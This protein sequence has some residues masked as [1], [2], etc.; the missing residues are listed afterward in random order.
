MKKQIPA[1]NYHVLVFAAILLLASCNSKKSTP[2]P[3]NA[4]GFKAPE[5][6]AFK[7]PE[8]K[9]LQWRDLSPDSI[10]VSST[11]PLNISSL[12]NKPFSVNEFK[13]LKSP[14]ASTPLNFNKLSEI[15]IKLDTIKGKP[16]TVKKFRLPVPVITKLNLPVK[17]D[18][19]TSG[20]VRLGQSE[21]LLGSQVYSMVTDR[22]GCIWISTEKGISRYTGDGFET[23]NFFSKNP[24]GYLEAISE[25]QIDRKGNLLMTAMISGIYRLNILTGIVQHYQVGELFIRIHE[26]HNGVLWAANAASGI[27][28]MDS[29]CRSVKQLILPGTKGENN[30]FGLQEDSHH[31]IW[32]GQANRLLIVNSDRNAI[33]L[34]GKDEGLTINI[35]FEFTEDSRGI[36]W[37]SAFSD[38]AHAISLAQDKIF[39]L[40][41]KQG[42]YRRSLDVV[43]DQLKRIW[44]MS[45]DTAFILDL[46]SNKIKKIPTGS[47]FVDGHPSKLM[48]DLNGTLWIGTANNGILLV[49]PRGPLSEHF[50]MAS[51]L[52]SNDVW[53]IKEDKFKRVWLATYQGINIYDPVHQKLYL[54]KLPEKLSTNNHR[55]LDLLD[56]DHILVSSINGFAII[57][58]KGNTIKIYTMKRGINQVYFSGIKDRNGKIWIG[59]NHGVTK[60]NPEQNVFKK[61]DQS[62]GLASNTVWAIVKDNTE[63]IWLQTEVELNYVD[64]QKN[65]LL[66]I[67]KKDGLVLDN[68]YMVLNT[69]KGEVLIGGDRGFSILDRQRKW[70]TNVTSKEGLIPEVMYDVIESNKRIQI[71]SE[72]GLIIV[73]Q[74][75]VPGKPWRFTNFGKQE[76]FPLNNYNQAT[77]TRTSGGQVWLSATPILTVN[78]QDPYIDTLQ[79]RA[80]I[81]DFNIMDQN[82]SF[83]DARYLKSTLYEG[84]TLWDLEKNKYFLK[85]NLP[86]ASAYL[87]KNNI[88]W[89]SLNPAFQMPVGLMLPYDQNSFN[90][91]FTNLDIKGRDK[92]VYRYTL[93]GAKESW[94]DASTK[95]VSKNYYNIKPGKYTFKVATRGFNG[96]WSKPAELSF[97][98]RPPWWQ[99]WWAYCI[100]GIFFITG[101]LIVDRFQKQ[102]LIRIERGR[103]QIRELEQAKEIE[104]AYTELKATQSQLI[105]SE[106]MASLGELTAGIAHEI[107][108]PLNF[109]NNFSEVNTELIEEMKQE[110]DKGN[111]EEVKAIANDIADNEQKIS[112]H[113]KRADAIVKGMLL[114][115]RSSAGVKEPADVNALADEYLRLSYHGLRAKDKSFNA[116]MKTDF[117]QSIGPINIIPQDIGRVIL[118]LIT[119]AFYAVT[120]KK[121][122]YP[123]GYEP[124]VSVSTKM[125]NGRVEI[126]VSDNGNGIPQ[127]V[128]DKIYQPFFTTKPS[129]QGTGLGLSMSYEIVTKGHDGELKVDTKEGEGTSFTIVL[130][131]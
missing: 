99:T 82:P 73:D 121:H 66:T 130:P 22:M 91:T 7:F 29:T 6:R 88:T 1:F 68:T 74:S 64:P 128:L 59:S 31:N 117:D 13:P 15:K 23:Y 50:N 16:V 45:Y 94:S 18:F 81:T 39:T 53:G 122:Q 3:E 47:K 84:D 24:Q 12:P 40:G 115:S 106:K 17:S 109:V 102:R 86:G 98:I 70:I 5:T 33:K 58:L 56:E 63:K 107:Q 80:W 41:P 4:S 116:T 61:I 96:V 105:Q 35:P 14:I 2:F 67:G 54:L 79:P 25:M 20:I 43:E 119:N 72:N 78:L 103:A 77:A 131:A 83:M 97:T 129:G 87:S 71:G 124:T 30:T 90:F 42:F 113:G 125:L 8:A 123:E 85:D 32:I 120:E 118:N 60:F 110:I 9:P 44:I 65:T 101:V 89:D 75:D 112:Q 49:D 92:I 114:H 55:R 19:T 126:K 57:D 38:E 36:V 34:I 108:N 26:D 27:F 76:G 37:I 127:K 69:N 28:F 10:P 104:K 111:L 46:A 21:G 100:Y 95:S 48:I 51:G 52:A 93:Q 11:I 62:S